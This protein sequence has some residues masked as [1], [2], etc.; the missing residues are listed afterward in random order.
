MVRVAG[1]LQQA[2]AGVTTRSA[3]GRT[4]RR[5]WP[6]STIVSPRCTPASRRSGARSWRRSWPRRA[7]WWAGIDDC[8][9]DELTELTSRFDR[10]VY[11]VLTP[12]AVGPGQPFPY[13]SGLSMSLGVFVREPDGGEERFARVKVPEVLPRFL[14]IG[15]RGL[16]L[17]LED[18]IA[19]FLSWLFPGMEVSEHV[20]FR[21]TRDADFEV[22]DEADDLLE[23]VELELRRRRFGDAVRLEVAGTAMPGHAAAAAGRAG[24]HRGPGLRHR[25]HARSGRSGSHRRARP[26]G[27]A[28]RTV[29]AGDPG[30][31]GPRRRPSRPVR[32]GTPGRPAGAPALRLVCH[33]GGAVRQRR[34]QGSRRGRDQDHRLPHQRRLGDVAGTDRRR[35]GGQ[36]DGLPGRAEGALRRAPQHRVVT[37][38]GAG[39][40]ARRVRLRQPQDPCQDDADRAPRRAGRCIATPTSAPATTTPSP[41]ASTRISGCSPTTRRSRPTWPTCS[42]ISPDSAGR[43]GFARSSRRRSTC[44]A[45]SP[46]GSGPSLGPRPTASAP[47]S[48]SR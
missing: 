20:V 46:S 15:Q 4:P 17:P 32:R 9:D 25:R 5:R 40:R 18:A 36:A 24:S 19:H 10:E 2:G 3:D 45:A 23:A 16:M 11:P 6:T 14:S 1:L 34:R 30:Q 31:A 8:T 39:R 26:P 29:D 42:T 43:S 28:V 44:A 47:A 27:A 38:D 7:S 48:A 12:L 35:R 22:S 13:V 33:L 41:P 37:R 21:V